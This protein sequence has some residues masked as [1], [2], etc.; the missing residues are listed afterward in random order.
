MD[1]NTFRVLTQLK[2]QASSHTEKL[3]TRKSCRNLICR[4]IK[5]SNFWHSFQTVIQNA[6]AVMHKPTS[7]LQ[8]SQDQAICEK[9]SA[10]GSL[11]FQKSGTVSDSSSPRVLT[12][13]EQPCA[14]PHHMQTGR[15]ELIE[16]VPSP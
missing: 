8:Y 11:Q 12:R 9:R 6:M 14:W 5:M 13:R 10:D 4:L 2:K 7:S 16:L 15:Q 1:K 3:I